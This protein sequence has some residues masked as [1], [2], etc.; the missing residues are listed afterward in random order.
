MKNLPNDPREL[1]KQ[2]IQQMP[3]ELKQWA[4]DILDSDYKTAFEKGDFAIA[5]HK[6]LLSQNVDVSL[7][8]ACQIASYEFNGHPGAYQI[9]NYTSVCLQMKSSTARAR[10]NQI[11]MSHLEW[12]CQ[13]EKNE[14]NQILECDLE[15]MSQYGHVSLAQLQKESRPQDDMIISALIDINEQQKLTL[16]SENEPTIGQHD[17]T[18]VLNDAVQQFQRVANLFSE[19][20][21]KLITIFPI[22]KK[23]NSR[24][25]ELTNKIMA[26]YNELLAEVDAALKV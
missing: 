8:F 5:V 13:F 23:E 18:E 9:M 7:M 10:Y 12:A 22:W 24:I 11:P 26:D 25:S 16:L 4:G 3:D 17:E 15:L 2:A 21:A 19:Q 20:I 14:R 1:F 6:W